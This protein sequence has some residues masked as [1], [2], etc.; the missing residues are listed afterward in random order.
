MTGD[1]AEEIRKLATRLLDL[2]EDEVQSLTFAECPAPRF[3][4]P[5]A[6]E[7]AS[8]N[9]E[10]IWIAARQELARRQVRGHYL[11]EDFF[12]EGA[13]N[14]LLDLYDHQIREQPVSITSAC[15]ASGVP[16]TTALRY[17][18]ILF[19]RN[20]I[21][22]TDDPNDK[23]RHFVRL[24]QQGE[25]AVRTTLAAQMECETRTEAEAKRLRGKR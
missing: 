12:A 16:P 17:L 6:V 13:W 1:E 19:T 10:A 21:A 9:S 20:F 14:I 2:T 22:R 24:T 25:L 3:Y 11:P 5:T 23:R 15:L 4:S 7:P 8:R 18:D